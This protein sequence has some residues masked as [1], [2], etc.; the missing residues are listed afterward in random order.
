MEQNRVLVLRFSCILPLFLLIATRYLSQLVLLLGLLGLVDFLR[1][2]VYRTEVTPGEKRT[3][4]ARLGQSCNVGA[5]R[6]R[7]CA[8]LLGMGGRIAPPRPLTPP[9]PP[10]STRLPPPPPAPHPR[11][12]TLPLAGA[13]PLLRALGAARGSDHPQRSP[14]DPHRLEGTA[15]AAARRVLATAMR[16]QPRGCGGD[17]R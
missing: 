14:A 3:L 13:A 10:L 16:R 9:Q 4:Q 8:L 1:A 11:P 5:E 15:S 6:D 17:S 2:P 12:T 7:G